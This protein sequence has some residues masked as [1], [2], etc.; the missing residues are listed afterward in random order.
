[1]IVFI[2]PMIVGG[3]S[4]P[5]IFSGEDVTKLTDAHRFRFDRVEIVGRDLMIEAYP[6]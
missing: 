4:A 3:A 1:M 5:A 6:G 2:A